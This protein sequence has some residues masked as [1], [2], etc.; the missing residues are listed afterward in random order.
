ML[1]IGFPKIFST[2]LNKNAKASICLYTA[3]Y[4]DREVGLD[5]KWQMFGVPVLCFTDKTDLSCPGVTFIHSP[6]F[7]NDPNRSAKIFKILPHLF[8]QNY[9]ISIWFDA[10][11]LPKEFDLNLLLENVLNRTNLALFAHP[12]R[13]C[14]YKEADFCIAQQRD[15]PQTIRNQVENYRQR[16]YPENNKLYA[17]GFLIRRHLHASIIKLSLLWWA[18]IS[19]FSRRDQLSMPIV[20]HENKIEAHTI[21]GCIWDNNLFIVGPH[22]GPE[23]VVV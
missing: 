11:M 21:E 6:A 23:S 4:G 18:E 9:S 2:N 20:M 10:N 15:N 3:I 19:K 5:S 8:L 14:I 16:H 7:F 13:D 22:A 17:S 1:K 12:E